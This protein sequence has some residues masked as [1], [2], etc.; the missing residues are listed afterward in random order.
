MRPA[1]GSSRKAMQ[2]SSVLLPDP[3]GPVTQTTSPAGL[4]RSMPCSTSVSPKRLETVCRDMALIRWC[5]GS[6]GEAEFRETRLE[7]PPKAAG[8]VDQAPT[9]PREQ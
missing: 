2:R 4:S 9:E 3:E 6:G 8:E 5:T 1:V 7:Q